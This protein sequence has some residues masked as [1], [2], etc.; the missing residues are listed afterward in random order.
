[1]QEATRLVIEDAIRREEQTAERHDRAA[2][3]LL[4]QAVDADIAAA[5][6][7][8]RAAAHRASLSP[9]GCFIHVEAASGLSPSQVIFAARRQYDPR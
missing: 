6:A 3:E 9:L 4:A 7:R 8:A 5:E 2:A 1:M